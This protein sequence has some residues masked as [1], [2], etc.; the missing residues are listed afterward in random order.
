M[1]R[2][3]WRIREWKRN[4]QLIIETDSDH[5]IWIILMMVKIGTIG[6]K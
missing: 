4:Y 3:G 1:G 5:C 6:V 2:L